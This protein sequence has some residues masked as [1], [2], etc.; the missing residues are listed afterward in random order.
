MSV[1]TLF[2]YGALRHAEHVCLED[3][4]EVRTYREVSEATHRL[5]M[6]LRE[7]GVVAGDKIATLSPNSVP[8]IEAMLGIYRA[9]EL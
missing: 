8:M 4:L 9:G 3:D 2:D 5:G 7:R 1:I 6:A